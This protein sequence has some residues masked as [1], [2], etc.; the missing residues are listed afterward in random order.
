MLYAKLASLHARPPGSLADSLSVSSRCAE[1]VVVWC[2]RYVLSAAAQT[3]RS[4]S[5]VNTSSKDCPQ[6]NYCSRR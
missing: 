6:I 3:S 4:I 1:N 2:M 5:A